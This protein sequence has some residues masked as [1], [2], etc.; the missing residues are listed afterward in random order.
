MEILLIGQKYKAALHVHPNWTDTYLRIQ[1]SVGN[2]AQKFVDS[3][4]FQRRC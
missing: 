3:F 1:L 2:L 4:L